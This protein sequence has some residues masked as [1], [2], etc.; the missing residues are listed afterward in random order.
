MTN[1]ATQTKTLPLKE[2]REDILPLARHFIKVANE[3][4][5]TDVK[6][7][8]KEVEEYLLNHDWSGDEKE[9]EIT[10]KRAC[11]L[12]QEPLLQ[13][14]DLDLRQRQIKSI[15]KFVEERLKGF[16][17]YIKRLERFNLYS[18]VIPEIEKALILMVLR[19]TKGNQIKAARILGINRN[20]L[21]NKI[22][23]L[24]IKTKS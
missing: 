20:T 7:L 13:I 4:L 11:I 21:R 16:M 1:N 22:K 14:E 19:E 18:M 17:G 2:R 9:L 24:G 12:S 10:I 6:G 8:S 3:Q 5:G 15:G 23:K